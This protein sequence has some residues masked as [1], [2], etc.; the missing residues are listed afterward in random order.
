MTRVRN[1]TRREAI[2]VGAGAALAAMPRA[3][4]SAEILGHGYSPLGEVRYPA[5]FEAFDYVNASAPKGGTMRLARIGAF[6]TVNTLVYP[7]R[8]PGDIRMIYD[9]LAVGSADERASYYGALAKGLYVS[10]DFARIV[11]RLHP[12]ARWTTVGRFAPATS[13]SHSTH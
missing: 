2:V 10:D 11:F 6:D 12:E 8:P 3:A 7:G 4:A 13:S 5:G 9:R 1:L